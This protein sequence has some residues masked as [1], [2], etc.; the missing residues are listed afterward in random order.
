MQF[1]ANFSRTDLD[2]ALLTLIEPAIVIQP[3][4]LIVTIGQCRWV[5]CHTRILHGRLQWFILDEYWLS[6][7][8]DSYMEYAVESTE[9]Q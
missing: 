4:V 5:I 1:L 2:T 7:V 8:A 9:R 3:L 6:K